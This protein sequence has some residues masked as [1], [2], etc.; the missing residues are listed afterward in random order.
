LSK[1]GILRLVCCVLLQLT[2]QDA[3]TKE[4]LAFDF[5]RFIGETGGDICKE[6]PAIRANSDV[7]QGWKWNIFCA[8][9]SLIH[10]YLTVVVYVFGCFIGLSIELLIVLIDKCFLQFIWRQKFVDV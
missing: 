3:H 7:L 4:L 2:I 5:S 1:L 8:D 10:I 9:L 6:L